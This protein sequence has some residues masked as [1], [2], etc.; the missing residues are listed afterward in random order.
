MN[1]RVEQLITKMTTHRM[2][3]AHRQ[4][5]ARLEEL[6]ADYSRRG[7]LNSGFA[8]LATATTLIDAFGEAARGL[9]SDYLGVA[10]DAGVS[11]DEMRELEAR[12]TAWLE[13]LSEG[14]RRRFDQDPPGRNRALLP[15]VDEK[16]RH[17]IGVATREASIVFGRELLRRE[18]AAERRTLAAVIAT[19]AAGE[20]RDFFVSH[21]GADRSSF[22]NA[23]VEELVRRGQSVWY[24]EYEITLGDSLRGK[25]DA[26]L[27]SSRFGIVVLSSAYFAQPWPQAELDALAARATSEGRK[28][29]LPVWHNITIDA[30]R[31][32]SPLLA[33]LAGIASS[34][35]V[36]AVVDAIIR[37]AGSDSKT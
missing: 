1:A 20:R 31:E 8:V 33:G 36:N 11:V 19:H 17:M 15:T 34:V 6:Q 13:N 3:E 29:I 26:G 4:Q 25:I 2:E 30:I 37:G 32:R 7:V 18:R 23:L 27:G 10:E 5:R 24:S 14:L 22:V 12:Y 9:L 28:V 35:G 21:A 16:L